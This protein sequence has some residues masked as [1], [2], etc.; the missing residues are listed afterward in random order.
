MGLISERYIHFDERDV[1]LLRRMLGK[2][3]ELHKG[4]EI[5]DYASNYVA[6]IPVFTIA[7]LAAQETTER[8]SRILVWLTVVVAAFSIVLAGLTLVLVFR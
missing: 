1:E 6:Y 2:F 3:Y 7:L 5:P 4:A 8:L